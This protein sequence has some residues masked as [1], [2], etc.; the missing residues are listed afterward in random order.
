VD[1][2]AVIVAAIGLMGVLGGQVVSR[3]G[4]RADVH[5]REVAEAAARE[6]QRF[7]ELRSLL[8]EHRT[9]LAGCRA[10]LIAL[11]D[12]HDRELG[13]ERDQNRRLRSDLAAL[14]LVVRDEATREA[15]SKAWDEEAP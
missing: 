12:R 9:D 5:Q 4:Q 3:V 2:N 10:E 6:H 1:A 7:E 11:R 15:A 13:A 8:A 14:V